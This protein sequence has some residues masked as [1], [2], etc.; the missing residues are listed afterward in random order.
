MVHTSQCLPLR[1]VRPSSLEDIWGV[2]RIISPF[3]VIRESWKLISYAYD[4]FHLLQHPLVG[5]HSDTFMSLPLVNHTM[6]ELVSSSSSKSH[7]KNLSFLLYLYVLPKFMHKRVMECIEGEN[8]YQWWNVRVV[9]LIMK[10]GLGIWSFL[11]C[12]LVKPLAID[13]FQHGCKV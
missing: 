7:F 10:R 11:S 5:H 6:C 1:I 13:G 4:L 8:P 2:L 9:I 12:V 3:F